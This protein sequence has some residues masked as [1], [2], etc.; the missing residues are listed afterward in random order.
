MIPKAVPT[1]GVSVP[2]GAGLERLGTE[3]GSTARA[4]TIN[5]GALRLERGLS[6]WAC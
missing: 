5:A 3:V 6:P 4:T 2:V 1:S